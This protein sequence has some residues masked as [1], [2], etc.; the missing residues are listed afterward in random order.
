M[1][2]NAYSS[3]GGT[4]SPE[5][6]W[7]APAP[8]TLRLRIMHTNGLKVEST[9]LPL[10]GMINA[11]VPETVHVQPVGPEP[12]VGYGRFRKSNSRDARKNRPGKIVKPAVSHCGESGRTLCT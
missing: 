1:Q 2:Q 5:I 7:M 11:N 4:R 12:G 3:T 9:C 10:G 8:G 6:P